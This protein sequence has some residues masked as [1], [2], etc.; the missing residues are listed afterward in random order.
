LG[1]SI[2]VV[3][4]AWNGWELTRR[5]LAHLRKQ[6]VAH[7]IIVCDN[8]SSDG[9][10]EHIK[11]SF[12]HVRLIELGLNVGFAAACNRGAHLGQ[13]DI[14]VLLNND[15]ECRPDFL[16]CLVRPFGHS[17]GVGSVASL[18]LQ[19]GEARIESFGLVVDST[20]AAYPRLR[21]RPIEEVGST[22]PTVLAGPSGAAGAYR[23]DAWQGVGGLDEAVFSYGEDADL[24][25]RLRAAGWAAATASDAVALHI[26][27]ATAGTRSEWQRYQGGFGRGYFLRRYGVLRGRQGPRA[28]FT[29]AIAVAGDAL[30]YSHDLAALRG[31]LAGWRA[32]GGK[33][34]N[35]RPPLDVIDTSITLA[36]S[37]RLR[38][39]VYTCT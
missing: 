26:G 27:S 12:S 30:V 31:R 8:G 10:P 9:T 37:L 17:E 23:R 18:L 19:P 3:I 28:V 2:D 22:T 32:A 36:E 38:R 39:T 34:R 14:V 35:A 1:S 11:A 33:P 20:L 6:T 7:T 4:P 15:V 5:C 21:N 24:A 29:E 16:E 13:G 25:L